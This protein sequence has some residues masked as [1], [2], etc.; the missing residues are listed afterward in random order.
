MDFREGINILGRLEDRPPAGVLIRICQDDANSAGA[1]R[2]GDHCDFHSLILIPYIRVQVLVG[3]SQVSSSLSLPC[4][5]IRVQ[6]LVGVDKQQAGQVPRTIDVELWDDLV[7]S[8]GVGDA[9]VVTGVV[10][11]L[12]TGDDLGECG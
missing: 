5:Q 12:A 1:C 7:G 3:I 8:C 9:V 10:K 6:E 2:K 4:L 11:V